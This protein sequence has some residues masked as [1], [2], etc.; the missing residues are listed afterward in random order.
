M[1][2]DE[3][4]SNK[5]N[6]WFPGFRQGLMGSGL[7]EKARFLELTDGGHFDNTAVYELIRRRTKLII[8]AM[9][10]CDTDFV[11][12]DL[13]NLAEKVRVDFSVFIEFNDT[14]YPLDAVRPKGTEPKSLSTRGFALGRIRY[15]KG[16][17]TSPDYDD[18]ILVYMQAVPTVSMPSDVTSYW[19][20]NES[21]PNDTTADQFFTEQN[22]EAYRELGYTIASEFYWAV[23]PDAPASAALLSIKAALRMTSQP[24]TSRPAGHL[25]A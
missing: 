14:A 12:Q 9:G 13:A 4:P 1:R 3:K 15:P 7:S 10:S 21:F 23:K 22:L 8:V 6:L 11:M 24:A 19:R 17:P 16:T 5:P 25:T 20:H 2:V 18:G